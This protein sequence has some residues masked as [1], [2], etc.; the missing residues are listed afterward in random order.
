MSPAKE[1]V[2]SD[3]DS[4]PVF[5]DHAHTQPLKITIGGKFTLM[6]SF[7][8]QKWSFLTEKTRAVKSG[9]MK[10]RCIIFLSYIMSYKPKIEISY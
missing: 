10:L 2:Q 7:Q 4:H 6:K 3:K 9:L 1:P 8:Y 5:S